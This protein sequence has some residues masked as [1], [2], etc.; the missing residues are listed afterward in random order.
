M[1]WFEWWYISY[2]LI[3]LSAAGLVPVL[4][5]LFMGRANGAVHIGLVMAA[6]SLGGL[7]AP[8]WGSLADY[9]HLH[10]RLLIGGLISIAAGAAW[11]PLVPIP[12]ARIVPALLAS[13]G[14]AAVSTVANLFVV[15]AHPKAEWD[16]RIGWLQTFYGGGQVTGLLIAG[17]LGQTA[18]ETGFWLA[19]GLSVIAIIPAMF[20]TRNSI[21]VISRPILLRPVHH[22]EWPALSP[23]HLYHLLNISALKKVFTSR[24]SAFILLLVAW[25]LSFAGSAAFFAFY[26]VLMEVQYG[27]L[28]GRS[29]TAYALAAAL[30]LILYAPSGKWSSRKGPLPI[31][32]GALGMRIVTFLALTI[33]A[34]TS[35]PNRGWI[36][37]LSFLFIVLAWSPLSVSSTALISFLSPKNEGEGIG[38]F[39]AVTALSGVIGAAVGGWT[40]NIWGYIAIPVI[41]FVGVSAGFL[42]TM[43]KRLDYEP[44]E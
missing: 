2:A 26:P 37:L 13:T 15:E 39:N 8:L 30:G 19:G 9:F 29:L 12:S 22:A 5:P 18:I 21:G 4:M 11:F 40:A 20:G 44:A 41:G 7:T 10:R 3:G 24:R 38:I 28:P 17:K 33:L 31:L 1:K 25:L 23:Q 36:A 43:A 35:L 27:V 6:F 34:I 32:R 16:V 14:L 42:V